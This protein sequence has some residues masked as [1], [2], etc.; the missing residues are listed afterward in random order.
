MFFITFLRYL[1]YYLVL[2]I[3]RIDF[4]QTN[5]QTKNTKI[6]TQVCIAFFIT[7]HIVFNHKEKIEM[8]I[9]ENYKCHGEGRLIIAIKY[10]KFLTKRTE[11]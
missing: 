5:K 6:S 3:K 7:I 11:A 4:L 1:R 2:K 8:L 10:R 9:Q